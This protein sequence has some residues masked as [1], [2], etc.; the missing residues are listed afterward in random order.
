MASSTAKQDANEADSSSALKVVEVGPTHPM[1]HQV[2]QFICEK[3]WFTFSA[4]LAS[5]PQQL[6]GLCDTHGELVAACGFSIANQRPL[7]SERYLGQPVE[8]RIAALFTSKVARGNIAEIG[9]LACR[10]HTFLPMLFAAVVNYANEHHIDYL[11]FTAT[12]QLR[13]HLQRLALPTQVL[14]NAPAVALPEAERAQWGQY[15]DRQPLVLAGRTEDGLRLPHLLQE[16]GLQYA[17]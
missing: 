9:S 10:N 5:L 11:L 8:E 3:Y 12:A 1:R 14:G 6:I 2:E 16:Q 4:C 7:F 13:R 17:R 15:Y